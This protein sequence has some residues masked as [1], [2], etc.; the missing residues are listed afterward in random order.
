MN[1]QRTPAGVKPPYA[2]AAAMYTSSSMS[3]RN[4]PYT[5]G[6]FTQMATTA[7]TKA[8]TTIR[9]RGRSMAQNLIKNFTLV[10]KIKATPV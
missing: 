1:A 3:V 4:P 10:K 8:A 5:H 9:E 6:Q 7:T 2:S